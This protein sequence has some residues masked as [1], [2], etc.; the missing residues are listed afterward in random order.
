MHKILLNYF[1]ENEEFD[2]FS[3]KRPI[4]MKK[5]SWI[6]NLPS[7]SPEDFGKAL[8]RLTFE[9]FE[10]DRMQN[11]SEV[12]A[13]QLYVSQR[14]VQKWFQGVPKDGMSPIGKE[15]FRKVVELFYKKGAMIDRDVIEA[16]ARCA[17]ED[18]FFETKKNWAK[19]LVGVDILN[20][21]PLP[22]RD[23]RYPALVKN[24]R[25]ERISKEIEEKIRPILQNQQILV[26]YGSPSV[27]KTTYIQSIDKNWDQNRL[28]KHLFPDGRLTAYLGGHG[29]R[30][31]FLHW[32]K[33]LTGYDFSSSSLEDLKSALHNAL[34]KKRVL[35]L[36]DDASEIEY[37]ESL[38]QA[39]LSESTAILTV[40]HPDI[41]QQIK[42]NK[43]YVIITMDGFTHAETRE[44]YKALTGEEVLDPEVLE[45]IRIYAEGNPATLHGLFSLLSPFTEKAWEALKY[46]IEDKTTHM[47]QK[48]KKSKV[49]IVQEMVYEKHLEPYLQEKFR[50]LGIAFN[51][52][53]YETEVFSA[54]WAC[55]V[56]EANR[57]LTEL[58]RLG[59]PIYLREDGLW[60]IPKSVLSVAEKALAEYPKEAQL[61][62]RRFEV[63]QEK[64][65]EE[66]DKTSMLKILRWA[67]VKK[68]IIQQNKA[69]KAQW[70]KDRL[71]SQPLLLGERDFLKTHSYLYTPKE[72]ARAISLSK[73]SQKTQIY[74]DH[75]SFFA[76]IYFLFALIFFAVYV[77]F[78]IPEI[79]IVSAVIIFIVL[80]LIN[81]LLYLY[82]VILLCVSSWLEH[83][84][85][86]MSFAR[87]YRSMT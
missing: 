18:Y 55:N 13:D 49:F 52:A 8:K 51:Y 67:D 16:F 78:A 1:P 19:K 34:E 14:S 9:T 75:F 72:A 64:K 23:H 62:S 86:F 30:K 43:K 22:D 25:R 20:T 82:R 65:I 40:S 42:R 53:A 7:N 31:A 35:L 73:R 76:P 27:G 71:S 69:L 80:P 39:D 3:E 29:P 48:L 83:S 60:H 37:A 87:T 21:P 61:V 17:G 66:L 28:F 85:F 47:P 63:W 36:V 45:A 4:F 68:Y 54:L 57:V 32:L 46:E 33:K 50:A 12:L 59:F 44:F 11:A 26:L 79:F 74:F 38:L 77:R 24:I 58:Q 5:N 10:M 70:K 6:L 41:F 81:M 2:S 56:D 84:H 15:H